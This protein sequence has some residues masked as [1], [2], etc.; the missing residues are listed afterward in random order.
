MTQDDNTEDEPEIVPMEDGEGGAPIYTEGGEP[1]GLHF[2]SFQE[3][4][5]EG[6]G[7]SMDEI[8]QQSRDAVEEMDADA[9]VGEPIS[10]SEL[11]EI[12]RA[13]QE[14]AGSEDSESSPDN[15]HN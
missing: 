1:F 2:A 7:K 11:A 10:L 8:E 5:A 6:D 9:E 15:N 3:L 12:I 14:Y 4:S 13:G